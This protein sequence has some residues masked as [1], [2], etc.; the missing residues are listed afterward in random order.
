MWPLKALTKGPI[1]KAFVWPLLLM[2]LVALVDCCEIKD[3]EHN[4][5]TSTS[6]VLTWNL[7][8]CEGKKVERYKAYPKHLRYKAC[9]A[10]VK[11]DAVSAV[12]ETFDTRVTLTELRPYSRYEIEVIAV[13]S[14]G[15][16]GAEKASAKMNFANPIRRP[17]PLAAPARPSI[18]FPVA[19]V[20]HYEWFPSHPASRRVKTSRGSENDFYYLR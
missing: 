3:L 16:D 20:T 14:G 13:V 17:R 7:G 9:D 4:S 15:E 8:D 12:F 5:L 11:D 1:I 18:E 10:G 6:V 19:N 2:T